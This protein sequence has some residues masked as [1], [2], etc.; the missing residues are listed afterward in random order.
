MADQNVATADFASAT[1]SDKPRRKIGGL[2][3]EEWRK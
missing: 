1:P 2:S 3:I